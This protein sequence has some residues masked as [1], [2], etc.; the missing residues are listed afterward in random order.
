MLYIMTM[1]NCTTDDSDASLHI[2]RKNDF[3]I[4]DGLQAGGMA[5]SSVV[6]VGSFLFA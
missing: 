4:H 3:T 6:V 5:S 2:V 1:M